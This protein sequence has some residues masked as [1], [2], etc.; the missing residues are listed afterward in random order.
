MSGNEGG[1]YHEVAKALSKLL[2]QK[3]LNIE[4]KTSSGSRENLTAL[5]NG[6]SDLALLQ[7]DISNSETLC[8]LTILYEEAL[9]LIVRK[10]LTSVEQLAG[11]TVSI[12]NKG[13]GT[14]G[15]AVAMLKQLGIEEENI[16]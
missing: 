7:N 14:E 8:S 4:V 16:R 6:I 2:F 10:E 11:S 5:T 12:G 3:G 1:K 15:I 13:G 9:H